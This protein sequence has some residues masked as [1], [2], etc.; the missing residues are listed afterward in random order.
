MGSQAMSMFSIVSV[1]IVAHVCAFRVTR[2]ETHS[3]LSENI[4][5]SGYVADS[6]KSLLLLREPVHDVK[7]VH[8]TEPE[9][10]TY[11]SLVYVLLVAG[12]VLVC[13]AMFYDM[14]TA[15]VI[16]VV[17]YICCLGFIKIALK[18]VYHYGFSYPTFTTALNVMTS[19]LVA[20]AVLLWRRQTT[21]QLIAV[22]TWAEL[23]FGVLPVAITF[24]LSIGLENF[25]LVSVTAAFSEVVGASTPVVTALLT[26][27]FGMGF[28]VWLLAPIAVVIMGCVV[29]IEGEVSFSPVGLVLLLISALVRA[30]KAVMLMKLMRGETKD[31]YDPMTVT[32]W[33]SLFSCIGLCGF[34]FV[35]EGLAP[36]RALKTETNLLGLLIALSW[37]CVVGCTLHIASVFVVKHLGAVG[38]QMVSQMKS[39]LVVMGGVALLSETFTVAQY[40]GFGTLLAGVYWFSRMS[41]ASP[42]FDDKACDRHGVKL[43]RP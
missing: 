36:L 20:F 16:Q 43:P 38:M 28:D 31:K 18:I 40:I 30:L 4:D 12:V 35:T 19:T 7:R 14:G 33:T 34:S 25:A 15:V 3:F 17:L 22:P 29:S 8:G 5:S 6:D 9:W 32:A 10:T 39:I 11:A 2:Y 23:F 21:G 41:I 13:A 1:C 27:V 37:S 24:G 26:W 42:V